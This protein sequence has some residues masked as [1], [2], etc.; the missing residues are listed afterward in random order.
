M[1]LGEI[2]EDFTDEELDEVILEVRFHPQCTDR[3]QFSKYFK[4]PT[5]RRPPF[6]TK[7]NL[8][9]S[10][11]SSKTYL[12]ILGL[13][14]MIKI[15]SLGRGLTLYT[16]FIYRMKPSNNILPSPSSSILSV[17]LLIHS[18]LNENYNNRTLRIY[19]RQNN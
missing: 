16:F 1:I 6:S 11:V 3:G 4:K 9:P 14:F 19:S 7:T 8:K 2:C 5:Q 18:F 17:N 15:S 12:Q 13:G 10:H